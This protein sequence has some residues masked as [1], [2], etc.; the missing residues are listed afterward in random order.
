M[1]NP[2]LNHLQDVTAEVAAAGR[3]ESCGG[4]LGTSAERRNA[5][6]AERLREDNRL[7]LETFLKANRG[8]MEGIARRILSSR[9][10]AE[11]AVQDAAVKALMTSGQFDP[12]RATD[13]EGGFR[14]WFCAILQNVCLDI[15]RTAGRQVHAVPM[16]DLPDYVVEE[17]AID[18]SMDPCDALIWKMG[19]DGRR[20]EVRLMFPTLRPNHQA[21]LIEC[22]INERR[23]EEV[24]AR[25]DFTPGAIRS[26]E[27]AARNELR[28]K[29][30]LMEDSEAL[31]S[32]W[33][34]LSMNGRLSELSTSVLPPDDDKAGGKRHIPHRRN[35]DQID[36]TYIG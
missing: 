19:L 7:R 11:D 31:E 21:V 36:D 24:A 33:N 22:V 23:P 10:S 9:C 2:D 26:M 8:A 17:A 27:M 18:P 28:I 16:C 13:L 34:Q 14:A 29:M 5:R 3:S 30:S 20:T 6:K 1:Q 15:G 12:A 35:L 25:W 4:R 32:A